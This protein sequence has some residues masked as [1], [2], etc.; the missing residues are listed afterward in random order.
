MSEQEQIPPAKITDVYLTFISP[1]AT[2]DEI[3]AFIEGIL[4]E[5]DE[6]GNR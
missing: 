1:D 3:N 6:D 4:G 2:D 5:D